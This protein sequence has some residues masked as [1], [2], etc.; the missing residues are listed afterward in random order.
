MNIDK[1]AAAI[2]KQKLNMSSVSSYGGL[3]LPSPHNGTHRNYDNTA[4]M[5]AAQSTSGQGIFHTHTGRPS[6]TDSVNAIRHPN[7]TTG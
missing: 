4:A 7:E 5:T 6:N 2:E 3:K 1:A